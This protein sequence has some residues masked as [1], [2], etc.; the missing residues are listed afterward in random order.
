M[1]RDNKIFGDKTARPAPLPLALGIM[2]VLCLV[3]I[4]SFPAPSRAGQNVLITSGHPEYAPFM[5]RQGDEIVGVG[6][7]LVRII[8]E[9]LGFEVRSPYMGPW[10]RVQEQAKQGEI[11]VLCTLYYSP[12]RVS[13]LT[14]VIPP[15]SPDP[16]V[17]WVKKG[18]A[19]PLETMEDLAGKNGTAV[20][21][22]SYGQVFD[23]FAKERLALSRVATLEQNFLKIIHG[24]SDYLVC[25]YYAGLLKVHTL[26]LE[27]EVEML[28]MRLGQ[29]YLYMAFSKQSKFVDRLPQVRKRLEELV[30]DKTVARLL[31]K[32][33]KALESSYRP[34]DVPADKGAE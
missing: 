7:D 5:Y 34:L 4:C 21:G 1:T 12:D 13:Y 22:E 20:L 16:F 17:A 19:F 30:I 2:P 32:H 23:S 31:E 15:Y 33:L 8:F 25:G 14:Y 10:K 24:R 29:E 3:A 18:H 6:P 26:N 9:E 11:D 27:D 28:S